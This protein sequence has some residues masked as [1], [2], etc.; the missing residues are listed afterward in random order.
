MDTA[1]QEF[2]HC[3]AASRHFREINR[4]ACYLKYSPDFPLVEKKFSHFPSFLRRKQI[5][6]LFD[7]GRLRNAFD[8]LDY[9][10]PSR[11]VPLKDANSD[12]ILF[13]NQQNYALR[14]LPRT[15]CLPFGMASFSF[16][17]D[18]SFLPEHFE[19]LPVCTSVSLPPAHS[20]SIETSLEGLEEE[21]LQ[22]PD[23]FSAVA[24]AIR[25]PRLC[26]NSVNASWIALNRPSEFDSSFAGLVFGFALTGNNSFLSLAFTKDLLTKGLAIVSISVLLSV[27]LK[28]I[29]SGD[30]EVASLIAPYIPSFHPPPE[31]ETEGPLLVQTAALISIGLLY[32]QTFSKPVVEYLLKEVTRDGAVLVNARSTLFRSFSDKEIYSDSYRMAA[33]IAIGLVCLDG[34]SSLPGKMSAL[35]NAGVISQLQKLSSHPLYSG[36]AHLALG[37]AGVRNSFDPQLQLSSTANPYH[38]FF[39]L[40]R[41]NNFQ[42]NGPLKFT[43]H[44]G[45]FDVYGGNATQFANKCMALVADSLS[46]ALGNASNCSSD[47][48]ARFSEAIDFFS[49]LESK[50][51]E[52]FS[53]DR[54]LQKCF[55]RFILI[56]SNSLVVSLSVVFAGSGDLEIFRMLRLQHLTY[57]DYE[58]HLAT[59]ISIG[60]LFLGCGRMCF[61]SSTFAGRVFLMLS[62]L[63]FYE[64][65]P[66]SNSSY[67][68][69]L[70]LF[71]IFA[72]T[73]AAGHN[74]ARFHSSL[75]NHRI[76]EYLVSQ[77]PNTSETSK[78]LFSHLFDVF[79]VGLEPSDE[80]VSLLES[81]ISHK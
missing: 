56:T 35:V 24:S 74:H 44:K 21:L 58:R 69:P 81:L 43:F 53:S 78:K 5:R 62:L 23:F 39:I 32:K 59:H 1:N 37:M 40:L 28:N 66:C 36:F 12:A 47:L 14:I 67:F 22:F 25:L 70:R 80:L 29:G 30:P 4:N 51:T 6:N 15:L 42:A 75:R 26:D 31:A 60:F 9:S 19:I 46:V 2:L 71:W 11:L 72:T 52:E 65:S 50:V 61:D 33:A 10:E 55:Q 77:L 34:G 49:A 17:A 13:E 38:R 57:A 27:A 45:D 68:P 63:P 64:T 20:S 7:D 73:A 16:A 3:L 41:W 8:M 79:E 18:D 76:Y 54:Y 48:K